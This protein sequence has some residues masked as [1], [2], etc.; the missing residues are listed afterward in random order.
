GPAGGDAGLAG[1]AGGGCA[2]G[3]GRPGYRD[4]GGQARRLPGRADGAE[5][6]MSDRFAPYGALAEALL[7]AVEDGGDGSHDVAHLHRVWLNARAI[8]AEA[9]GDGEILAAAVL[10]HDGVH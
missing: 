10:L 8:A 4:A 2:R 5:A 6:G 1:E 7:H 3:I 9:G